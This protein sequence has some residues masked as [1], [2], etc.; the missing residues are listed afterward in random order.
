MWVVSGVWLGQRVVT[1]LRPRVEAHALGAVD[2]V[3]AEQRVLPAAEAVEGHRHRDRD[4]DADHADLDPA[5]EL[6]R[7]LA[8][9]GEDRRAVGIGAGVDQLDRLVQRAHAHDGEDRAEDLV[10]CRRSCRW[11]RCRSATGRPR[12]R[13]RRARARGRRRPRR[14]RR[15]RC[16]PT[17][18]SRAAPV[19]SGPI[20][21]SGS[22]PGPTW[23][24]SAF[25]R[26]FST[27]SSATSPTTTATLIAMHRWPALPIAGRDQM[28]GREVQVGVGHHDR[29]VLGPAQCLHAL[30]VRARALVDVPGDRGRADERDRR[31]VGMVEQ[32]VD[33]DLVAVHDVEHA[34]GQARLAIEVG[35]HIGHARIAL[36]GLEHERVPRRDRRSGASTIGTMIGKLNGVIPAHTPSGWRNECRSTPVET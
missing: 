17:T 23:I 27:S 7:R 25:A 28:V 14:P 24:V 34:V 26:S 18:R 20:S 16:S 3:V 11:R 35:D 15:G 8:A 1:D 19:T 6:A 10:A 22:S 29:V 13:R 9:R 12:S 2:V 30:T 32:R 33:R 5:L 31:D 21:D 36:G 4:V